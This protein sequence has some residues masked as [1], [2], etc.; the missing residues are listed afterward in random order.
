MTFYDIHLTGQRAEEPPSVY[1]EVNLEH[2]ITGHG[3]S[4]EAVRKALAMVEDKYCPAHVM[5][6]STAK[7]THTYR[8]LDDARASASSAG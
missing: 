4:E 1:T 2:T 8:I 6:S 7:M 3:I 5:F